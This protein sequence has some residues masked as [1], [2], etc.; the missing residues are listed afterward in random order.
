MKR[1]M[2]L[3]V[4][5][6][7]LT[8]AFGAASDVL[9]SAATDQSSSNTLVT[10]AAAPVAASQ[11]AGIIAGAIGGS[12]GGAPPVVSGF[13]DGLLAAK[14]PYFS[15]RDALRQTGESAG[16]KD[17]KFNI[18]GNGGYTSIERTDTGGEL[19]GR[20]IN[21]VVGLDYLFQK[22]VVA[23]LAVGYEDTD[24]DTTFNSGTFKGSGY[25]VAPYVG[26]AVSDKLTLDASF[27]YSWVEYDTT[28]GAQFGGAT[29]SFDATRYFIAAN[30]T[31]R[32]MFQNNKLRLSP[33]V[34]ILY[35]SEDQDAFTTSAG[36]A[37]AENTISLGRATVGAELGYRVQPMIEPYLKAAVE[38]DWEHEDAVD[39]GNGNFS[40]DDEVGAVAGGGIN[41]FLTDR[42]TG[43]IEGTMNSLGRDNLEVWSVTGKLNYRF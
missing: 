35:L 2:R 30:A 17:Y 27:G 33:K 14:T 12:V 7:S 39:L 31:G 23:G 13:G 36:A 26:F 32:Y 4:A 24:V 3:A 43:R 15:L 16:A 20:V 25:T 21:G 9:A 18:W 19:D 29:S 38:Y 22:N 10:S 1:T 41:L 11:A 40:S 8:A 34:G 37:V 5:G 6:L 42:L 28:T